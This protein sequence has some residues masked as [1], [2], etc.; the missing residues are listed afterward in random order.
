MRPKARCSAPR[1]S[2]A[3]CPPRA[4]AR[5]GPRHHRPAGR[6][7]AAGRPPARPVRR[8]AARPGPHPRQAAGAAGRQRAVDRRRR[9]AGLSTGHGSAMDIAGKGSARPDALLRSLRLLAGL[10]RGV[11]HGLRH[12]HRRHRRAVPCDAGQTVL[13]AA[14]KAGIEMPYS[15]RKG[16]CG[17]CAGGIARGEFTAPRP[18]RPRRPASSCSASACRKATWRSSRRPGTASTRR[19]ARPSRPRCSAT[20]WRPRRQRAAVAPA[21]RQARQVQG[22][23]VPA[24]ALD[25]GSRRSYSMANPPHESDMLQLHVRHVPGGRFSQVVAQLKAGDTLRGRAALRHLR[26]EA[27]SRPR[28]CCAWWAAPASRR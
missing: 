5:A 24:G 4:P 2:S 18:T 21:G 20:R 7:R 19:R 10:G 27:R 17:N 23:P 25:D 6:R 12:P 26:A 3:W 15:C 9:G 16:V 1:T 22:R 28:R 11:G 14:L 13:D 8:H